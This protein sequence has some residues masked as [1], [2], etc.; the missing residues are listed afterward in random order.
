MRDAPMLASERQRYLL[1]ELQTYGRIT[2]AAAAEE[3]GAS[4]ETIRKD[5]IHLEREGRLHRVHGGALPITP[6]TFEPDV[7]IRDENHEEKIRIARSAVARVPDG[8]AIAV[9][10]GSTT[11]EFVRRLPDRPLNVY[12]T[13]LDIAVALSH[14]RNIRVS[15]FGGL[16]RANTTAQVGLVAINA[17]ERMH[18]DVSFVGTNSISVERGLAT[19]DESESAV[20]SALIEHG[21]RVVLLADHTKFTQR[22]LMTYAQVTDLDVVVTGSELDPELREAFSETDTDMEFV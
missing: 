18:F 5:L 22:S 15:T 11:M 12:T 14:H 3:I 9:D 7:T 6:V 21:E 8:G 19:P 10:A 16:V 13:A 1:N 2:A 20:K 17:I 4:V